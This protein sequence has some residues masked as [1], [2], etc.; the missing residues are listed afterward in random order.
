M[1]MFHCQEVVL[2]RCGSPRRAPYQA[3]VLAP[4]VPTCAAQLIFLNEEAYELRAALYPS[5][6]GKAADAAPNRPDSYTRRLCRLRFWQ[7]LRA[8]SYLGFSQSCYFWKC[9]RKYHNLICSQTDRFRFNPCRERVTHR[10][11][12]QTD[13][14]FNQFQSIST[15]VHQKIELLAKKFTSQFFARL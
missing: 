14:G 1:I 3:P 12:A 4:P 9:R 15:A 5:P 11:R 13:S 7:C 8:A 2:R 6:R 10:F